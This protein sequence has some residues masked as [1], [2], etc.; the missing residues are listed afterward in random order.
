MICIKVVLCL[1]NCFVVKMKVKCSVLL[2]IIYKT[3]CLMVN[4][5]L[6]HK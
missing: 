3:F 1:L 6:S 4:L 2:H 5:N